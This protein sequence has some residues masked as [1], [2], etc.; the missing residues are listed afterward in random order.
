MPDDGRKLGVIDPVTKDT[1]R[2]VWNSSD[3]PTDEDI[4]NILEDYRAS[5]PKTPQG[6]SLQPLGA[7]DVARVQPQTFGGAWNTVKQTAERVGSGQAQTP[8]SSPAGARVIQ[9]AMSGLQMMEN[10]IAKLLSGSSVNARNL[11]RG[12]IDE[13]LG[14]VSTVAS[15]FSAAPQKVNELYG[16]AVDTGVSTVMRGMTESLPGQ[17]ATI[18]KV[19]YTMLPEEDKQRVKSLIGLTGQV[20][21]GSL[22][23]GGANALKEGVKPEGNIPEHTGVGEVG[24]TAE[25]SSGNS[26]A[27]VAQAQPD[28]QAGGEPVR[29]GTF[30][31]AENLPP[32]DAEGGKTVGKS[33]PEVVPDDQAF[34]NVRE[35]CKDILVYAWIP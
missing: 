1:V 10:P 2:F 20:A 30:K 31:G 24:E 32:L 34:E 15:P 6:Q 33:K 9:S 19:F 8:F 14:V 12:G 27:S 29:T 17:N 25:T 21:I 22:L 13:F 16:K 18:A 23:A 11:V 7:S 26:P 28:V 5:R 3:D 35:P 4:T